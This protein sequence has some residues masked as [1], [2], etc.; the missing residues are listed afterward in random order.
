[1][2]GVVVDYLNNLWSMGRCLAA[3]FA[4]PLINPTKGGKLFQSKISQHNAD[5]VSVCPD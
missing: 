3:L 5:P 2:T 4:A 1:M